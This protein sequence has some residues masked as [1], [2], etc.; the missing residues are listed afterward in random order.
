MDP[1]GCMCG[2]IEIRETVCSMPSTSCDKSSRCSG[3]LKSKEHCCYDICGA[4]IRIYTYGEKIKQSLL[5]DVAADL[6][7]PEQKSSMA[8]TL[9]LR[10]TLGGGN[11]MKKALP[12]DVDF[13]VSRVG[14]E[15]YEMIF[16]DRNGNVHNA[17]QTARQAYNILEATFLGAS[18]WVEESGVSPPSALTAVGEVMGTLFGLAVV[19]GLLYGLSRAWTSSPGLSAAGVARSLAVRLRRSGSSDDFTGQ[20]QFNRFSGQGEIRTGMATSVQ[21]FVRI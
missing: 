5:E 10:G 9:D 15:E 13:S 12:S 6:T 20:F 7:A 2:N 11:G 21:H 18:I 1:A 4:I 16:V 8:E 17:I 19:L 3:G 14:T